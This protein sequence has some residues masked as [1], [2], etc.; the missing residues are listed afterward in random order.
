LLDIRS[1]SLAFGGVHALN[2]LS[3]SVGRGEMLSVM[4]P[5]GCGKTTLLNAMTGQVR[6]QSGS[7]LLD[8]ISLLGKAPDRIARLGVGRKF[9]VPSV[10]DDLSVR[11]NLLVAQSAC[12]SES[13]RSGMLP[14]LPD[15]LRETFLQDQSDVMAGELSHGAK[16]WLEIGMLLSQRPRLMLLDEP[17]AGMSH[18]ETLATVKLL[19]RLQSLFGVAIVVVEHDMHFIEALGA[20]VLVM[21]AGRAVADGT[22][23]QVRQLQQVREAYLGTQA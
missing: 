11:D 13:S 22:Y 5:N 15:V 19:Q 8:G 17:T 12:R 7:A 21:I 16:Q 10:F 14:E 23:A 20:R 4:G 1:L 2:A 3:L 9:Q 6:P 18:A